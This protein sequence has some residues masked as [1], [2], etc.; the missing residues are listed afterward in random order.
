VA[1]PLLQGARPEPP[2]SRPRSTRC[3]SPG[4]GGGG[5]RPPLR[6]PGQCHYVRQSIQPPGGG[7]GEVP[8]QTVGAAGVESRTHRTTA[9]ESVK[10]GGVMWVGAPTVRMGWRPGLYYFPCSI[11][12]SRWRAIM[13]RHTHHS[14]L[15]A[16]AV[17]LS[18]PTLVVYAGLGPKQF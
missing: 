17:N 6:P 1:A 8:S 12:S 16:L 13:D 11:K 2:S 9:N 3:S 5:R 7:G 14:Q 10:M 18:R 4:R 15:K